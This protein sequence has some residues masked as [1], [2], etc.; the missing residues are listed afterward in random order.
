MLALSWLSQYEVDV[1]DPIEVAGG[2]SQWWRMVRQMPLKDA[3]LQMTWKLIS[4][5][6]QAHAV[7]CLLP[8]PSIG[9]AIECYIA[10]QKRRPVFVVVARN[11]PLNFHP[12][13]NTFASIY[14]SIP[15]AINDLIATLENG[16][17]EDA[18]L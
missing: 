1:I 17:G 7:L 16:G 9:C 12:F 6:N 5:L 4:A 2:W 13:L 14:N 11:S 3:A 18:T 15:L 8:Q 10:A